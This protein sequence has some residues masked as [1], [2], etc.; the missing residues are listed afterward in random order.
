MNEFFGADIGVQHLSGIWLIIMV[1][2]A[3]VC[4]LVSEL[5]RNYS[6][7]DK[8]WS[9]LPIGY[10]LVTL[11]SFPGPRIWIMSTLVTLWGFRLSYNFHRKGGYN[12]IPWKGEEDYRWTI[13]RQH[14]RLRGRILFGLF[15]LFF[16]SFYQNIL[17]LLFSTPL[18]VAAKF[19][20]SP[21]TWI[22]MTA[23]TLMLLFLAVETVADN[24]LFRFQ[25]MKKQRTGSDGLYITSLKNG[26]MSE[27]L[28]RYVRHPNFAAEQAIWISFYLF[29]AAA[30]GQLLNWTLA[31]SF[32]LVLLFLG[33][34][35]MTERISSSKYPAYAGYKK[36]VPRFLL[37]IFK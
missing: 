4:F 7:V 6:Q 12:I 2:A 36:E 27:G 16:I 17:I 23:A 18:L 33:S 11:A 37:R 28:W 8:L 30:S 31:G 5:T 26:F 19:N 1:T 34:S 24:Q 22:D 15:N 3:V 35:E 13:L 14:P 21:L 10:S 29:S 20:T 9:L 25:K 32:L